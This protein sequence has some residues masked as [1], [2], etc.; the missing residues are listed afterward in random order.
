[1][2]LAVAGEEEQCREALQAG[3]FEDPAGRIVSAGTHFRF[4][5]ALNAIV[6]TGDTERAAQYYDAAVH[7]AGRY[8][9]YGFDMQIGERISGMVALTAGRLDDAER[10]LVEAQFAAIEDPNALDAPHV[11]YWMARLRVAQG[12]N[13]EAKTYA[14]K[15]R[16][17]FARLGAPPFQA[18]AEALLASL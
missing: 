16:D 6:A 2:A 7:E 4:M 15:A 12:R 5:A 3:G 9:Y 10:H 1:M 13:D 11:D 18:A 17:E 14:T 8:R